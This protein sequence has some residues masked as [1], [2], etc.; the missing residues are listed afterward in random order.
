MAKRA[1]VVTYLQGGERLAMKRR[2]MKSYSRHMSPSRCSCSATAVGVLPRSARAGRGGGGLHRRMVA[3]VVASL[4]DADTHFEQR[5]HVVTPHAMVAVCPESLG[6]VKV[7]GVLGGLGAGVADVAAGVEALRHLHCV[8]GAHAQLLGG[9]LE[10]AHGVE[11]RRRRPAALLR[12][13]GEELRR[14]R[15]LHPPM[16]R[17]RRSAVEEAP[18]RPLQ[19]QRSPARRHCRREGPIGLRHKGLD[20]VVP[21]HAEAQRWSLT[22]AVADEPSVEVAVLSLEVVRLEPRERRAH[23]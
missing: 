2:V 23:F 18:A 1:F 5:S 21:R 14:G 8:V 6:G 20:L 7:G 22:R 9:G 19:P 17:L 12:A 13:R 11:R 4:R 16:E 15:A 3:R 10:E